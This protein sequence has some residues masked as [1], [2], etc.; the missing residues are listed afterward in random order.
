MIRAAKRARAIAVARRRH[1]M[2]AVLV[3]AAL[4]LCAATAHAQGASCKAQ[5]AEK[6]LAGPALNNFMKT[7]GTEAQKKCEAE[8]KEKKLAGAEKSGHMKKCVG[9]AIGI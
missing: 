3:A 8:A 1:P 6:K 2:R 5:A 9:G 7:C 4:S